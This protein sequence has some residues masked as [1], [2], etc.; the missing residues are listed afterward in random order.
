[1]FMKIKFLCLFFL[2]LFIRFGAANAQISN[3]QVDFSCPGQV[4]VT[5][6][7]NSALPIDVTLYYSHNKCDWLIAQTV[8]GD[9]MEQTTGTGK[10][11]IW[12]SNTDNVRVGKFY[13]KVE[14]PQPPDEP[15]CVMINGVCWATRNLG[16]GGMFVENPEDY[17]ALYQWG[18]KADGHENH[19]SETVSGPI[20]VLDPNGQIP[21]GD[22]AYGKFIT[23][24]SSPNDWRTPQAG[25]LWNS[26]TES[27]PTKTA[28]DP[29]PV[30]WRV[31]TQIELNS[32]TQTAYVTRVWTTV[33]GINGY[34][35]TDIATAASIFLPA[36]NYRYFSD[37]TV[38]TME[39]GGIYWS[40]NSIGTNANCLLFH[41][42]VFYTNSNIRLADPVFVA[43]QNNNLINYDNKKKI[44]Q[45]ARD[46]SVASLLRNDDIAA[47]LN[48]KY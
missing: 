3:T 12:D 46:S 6:D 48:I 34:R 20:S 19:T 9:L 11:I 37:G 29:C 21:V 32:L 4:T 10:T 40:S 41:I 42:G 16:M 17:G 31:P 33:N 8:S 13:F 26:G 27:A 36:V 38:V 44:Q 35:C 1:M 24:V 30:G 43:S 2:L 39:N 45:F 28:N 15:E 47:V 25:T 22:A 23:A 14:T 18:R 7:L 5:Y